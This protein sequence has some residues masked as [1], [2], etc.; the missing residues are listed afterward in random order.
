[1]TQKQSSLTIVKYIVAVLII[2]SALGGIFSGD[3]LTGLLFLILGVIILPPISDNLKEKVKLWQNKAVRYVSYFALMVFA[4]AFINKD[5]EN[6][7]KKGEI[8]NQ[9]V[10]EYIQKDTL[11]KSLN[12]IRELT[13]A[14][15]L[16]EEY[17]Y[18]IERPKKHLEL[19][20]DTINNTH[21]F[22]FNT[23]FEYKQ[24]EEAI[25]FLTDNSSKGKLQDYIIKFAVD[26][27]GKIL[28][29]QTE[30]T[31][32]K[33]GVETFQNNEVPDY[34]TFLNNDLVENQ[35]L[36]KEAEKLI[37][38]QKEAY[39]KRADKFEEY[40]LSSWDGSHIELKRLV[41]DNMNDPES[42]EHV[43]TVY[44]LYSGYGVVTMQFRGKNAFGGKVL[45]SVTAKVSLDDC[46]IIEVQQNQ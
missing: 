41:E 12:N 39:N 16:F 44:R 38:K 7:T 32:S 21:T 18:A 42:F 2:L 9:F 8:S 4:G 43:E 37:A 15:K 14:G 33:S 34:T 29:K 23:K 1:M 13:E 26:S 31:Y 27:T 28:S 46:S 20:T 19:I 22:V 17:N 35:K 25:Q 24:K 10:I 36:N 6:S 30:I 11:D 40:C 45:N 3:I 5:N